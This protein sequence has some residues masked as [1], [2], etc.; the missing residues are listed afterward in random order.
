MIHPSIQAYLPQ[1]ISLL[2]KHKIKKAYFFG[3]VLTEKFNENSDVDFLV[4]IEENLD[5]LDA[6][7]HLWDLTHELEDLLRRN[8]DLLTE[9]SLRNSYFIDE[10]NET[11]Y[12]IYG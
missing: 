4:S 12:P 8:V 5:P 1:V 9:R 7:G 6:G 10:L 11:K 2:E 3:S